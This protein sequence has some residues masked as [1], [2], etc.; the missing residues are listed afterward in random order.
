LI[1]EIT[2]QHNEFLSKLF[3]YYCLYGEPLNA[4]KLKSAKFIKLLRDS[5]IL[6]KGVLK[7][8]QDGN[9]SQ[10]NIEGPNA[11]MKPQSGIS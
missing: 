4:N 11:G 3:S 1:E 10:R 7:S 2:D 8:P 5:G 9:I 6:Y